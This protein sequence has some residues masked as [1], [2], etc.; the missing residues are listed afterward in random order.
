M[1][2]VAADR[3]G[4][5]Y[6]LGTSNNVV[7]KFT[8]EGRFVNRFGG[9]GDEPGQFTAPMALAVDE[10]GQVYVV[11]AKGIQVFDSEGRYLGL[12][13]VDDPAAGL[14]FSDQNQLFVVAPTQIIK[15]ILNIPN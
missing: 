9:A 1:M 15:Y 8:S 2:R 6:A 10:Q 11:D 13:E 4:N 3:S 14:V 5:I 12:I 7:L